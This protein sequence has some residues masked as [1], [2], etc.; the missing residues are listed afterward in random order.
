METKDMLDDTVII[1]L[2]PGCVEVAKR[3][4]L[5]ARLAP[6]AAI[7]I[8]L[9]L[10]TLSRL[11]DDPAPLTLALV[12][13]LLLTGLIDGLAAIGLY[14]LVPKSLVAPAA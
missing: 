14:R 11:A 8:A 1:A 6:V 10:V 3:S 13:R 4:G 7:L 5:P 2:V 12:A 9:L